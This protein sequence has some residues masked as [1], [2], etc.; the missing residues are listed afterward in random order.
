MEVN[1]SEADRLKWNARYR[2]GSHAHVATPSGVLAQHI[3]QAQGRYA[4]DVASGAGRNALFMAQHGYLVD[5]LDISEAGL[6]IGRRAAAAQ[7]LPI[8]WHQADLQAIETWPRPHYDLIVMTHFIAP[9][10]LSRLPAALSP[11]GIIM[12]EQHLRWAQPVPGGLAGPSSA[13]YR[14]EP[15]SVLAALLESEPALEV[16]VHEEGLVFGSGAQPQALAR[17]VVLKP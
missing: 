9:V 4:L 6:A 12:V 7:T 10:L 5:A 16:C 13:R 11:G 15:G 2:S 8:R 3:G 17:V 14:V 1:N